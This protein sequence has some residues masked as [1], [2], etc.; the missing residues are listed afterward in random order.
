MVQHIQIDFTVLEKL[1]SFKS[2][3]QSENLTAFT[4][5]GRNFQEL[6]VMGSTKSVA[7]VVQKI[8]CNLFSMQIFFDVDSKNLITFIRNS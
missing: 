4:F 2:K 8:L 5:I 3:N 6:S 1:Q 7:F